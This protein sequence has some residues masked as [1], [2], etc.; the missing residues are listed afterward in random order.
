MKKIITRYL[1]LLTVA[2]LFAGS[3]R[4]QTSG[5][6]D[7][8]GYVWRD[9]ND[10]NGPAYNWIDITVDSNAVLVTGLA[11][12]NIRGPF[13]VGFPFHY[14][15]YDVTTFRVG[16]NGYVGFTTTP[17]AHPFPLI[18]TPTGIQNYLAV[19]TSDLTFTDNANPPQPVPNAQCWYWTSP[20]NDTLIVSYL[21]V[22]L[23]DPAAP[24]YTGSN[25]FQVILSN[26]DSSITYQYQNQNGIYN[27]PT[28]FCTIGIE[29]NSGNI[30][31]QHSHDI[32]PPSAYAIKFYY[33]P[34][35]TL[36]ISDAATVFNNNTETGG[37][38]L[39][40]NGGGFTMNTQI[41]NTG[42]QPLPQYNVY[43][44]VVNN[45]NVSQATSTVSSSASTPGQT[46]DITFGPVFTPTA[47]GA[48]R[49]INDTQ[50]PGDATPS[51][52]QKVM[53]LQVVDTTTTSILLS[54]DNGTDAGLGGLSWQ[55]GGGGAGIEFVPPFYPCLVTQLR[56]YIVANNNAAGFYLYVLDDDGINGAPNTLL[57][58]A[59]VDPNSVIV[60]GWNTVTLAN[61]VLVTSGSFYV[62]WMMD[63]DGISIGQNQLPPF[64]NRTYEVLGSA[65]NSASWSAYRYREIEDIMLNAYISTVPVGIQ[66]NGNSSFFGSFY[67]NP[68]TGA[69][70]LNY[71]FATTLPKVTLS[72]YNVEGKE[73]MH[74]SLELSAATGKLELETEGLSSGL[75]ICRISAGN[76]TISRKF[77]IQR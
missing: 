68:S 31:L 25:T 13:P 19:M 1:L 35:V 75:Y 39:S 24:G 69:V 6:P 2:T 62:A 70:A 21:N 8:Y 42:N 49:Y 74:K 41:K 14:Y 28:D 64:S 50:L 18:P 67:P 32:F 55:G 9:S 76:E 45:L 17:V 73:V 46:E 72:V 56:A 29:N 10:P 53:E 51:N 23:W 65:L 36:A 7:T 34:T 54:F 27:N 57:E 58:S 66:E 40:K 48:F 77:T 5:G 52:N 11:D 37:L 26:V 4:A 71:S 12:D 60:G 20:N 47:T 22:P 33:P 63:G 61:P 43:S 59:Y 3:V 15:W 44:R 16:S 38:F 30:G